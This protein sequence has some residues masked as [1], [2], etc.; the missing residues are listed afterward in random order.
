MPSIDPILSSVRKF[1][2]SAPTD[3]VVCVEAR[4][5]DAVALRE[6]DDEGRR[7]AATEVSGFFKVTEIN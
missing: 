7:E 2:L 6:P 3:R 5:L 4:D 1:I